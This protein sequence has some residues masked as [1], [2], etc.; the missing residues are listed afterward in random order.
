[1]TLDEAI[2][3]NFYQ[4]PKEVA[5]AWLE[6]KGI[7]CGYRSVEGEI[8]TTCVWDT[9]TP[10]DCVHASSGINKTDCIHWNK[11]EVRQQ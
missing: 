10:F 6:A 5:D 3:K 7:T 9:D 1:M 4:L 2:E 8:D 11:I